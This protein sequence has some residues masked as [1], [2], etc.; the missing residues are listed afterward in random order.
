MRL[1]N[2]VRVQNN[3]DNQGAYR[4][5]RNYTASPPNAF[6]DAVDRA[7][8][9]ANTTRDAEMTTLL[10]Q[11]LQRPKR[12]PYVDVSSTVQVCGKAACQP[13]PVPLRPTTDFVWQR[14]PF[15]LAGGGFGTVEGAGVDYILPYWMGR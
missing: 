15:Q 1:Y 12:D 3:E 9:G 2:V 10:D 8:Q 6:F 14:D 11:W 13:V 5:L 7:L 4:T